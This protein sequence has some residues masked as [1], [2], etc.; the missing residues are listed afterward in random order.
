MQ[1]AAPRNPPF[2]IELDEALLKRG[3]YRYYDTECAP[4][5]FLIMDGLD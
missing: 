5:A 4:K 1:V 3:V 2:N